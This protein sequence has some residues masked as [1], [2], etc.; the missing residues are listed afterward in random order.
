MKKSGFFKVFAVAG[1]FTMLLSNSVYAYGTITSGT[2]D[3]PPADEELAQFHAVYKVGDKYV[4]DE[5]PKIAGVNPVVCSRGSKSLFHTKAPDGTPE[6]YLTFVDPTDKYISFTS[7]N[8]NIA[9]ADKAAFYC[10]AVGRT[11]IHINTGVYS[12]NEYKY[13]YDYDI[14]VYDIETSDENIREQVVSAIDKAMSVLANGGAM[15]SSIDEKTAEMLYDIMVTGKKLTTNLG[16]NIVTENNISEENKGK[17][18]EKINGN[19]KIVS[20]YDINIETSEENVEGSGHVKE[21]GG[22]IEVLVDLPEVEAPKDGIKRSYFAVLL[23]DGKAEK[24]EVEKVGNKGKIKSSKFSLYAIGYSDTIGS[25][26]TGVNTNE[27]QGV[28]ADYTIAVFGGIILAELVAIR[29]IRK[30]KR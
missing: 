15:P 3:S 18:N 6:N 24:I 1:A 29:F 4:V 21:L 9:S 25:P 8:E 17:I 20:Y 22:D 23:H 10:K 27:D 2:F 14:I 19:D 16:V 12:P 11:I 5:S 7:D 13:N 28:V 26:D 30:G